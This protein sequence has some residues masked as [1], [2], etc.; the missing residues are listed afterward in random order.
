MKYGRFIERR[1]KIIKWFRS[2]VRIPG[3]SHSFFFHSPSSSSSSSPSRVF[4]LSAAVLLCELLGVCVSACA[5]AREQI[6]NPF[7]RK[8]EGTSTTTTATT[9]GTSSERR[10][11]FICIGEGWSR[12]RKKTFCFV[13]SLF[14]MKWDPRQRKKLCVCVCVM[15]TVGQFG[16]KSSFSFFFWLWGWLATTGFHSLSDT[17]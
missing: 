9:R 2:W 15:T 12:T 16:R 3:A 8:K 7:A 11:R 13:F 17:R 1:I 5:R 10:K 14:C 6:R 4:F